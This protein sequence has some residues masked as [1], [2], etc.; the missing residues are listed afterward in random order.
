LAPIAGIEPASSPVNGRPRAPCSPDGN[1]F[2]VENPGVEPGTPILQGSTAARCLPR[3]WSW[4]RATLSASSARRFHQISLP[5]ALARMPVI[6]TGPDEWR[7]TAR[8]S[9]YTRESI[10]RKSGRRFSAENARIKN[11]ICKNLIW[12]E[13]DGIEPLARRDRVYSAA[14]APACPYLHFPI[15]SFGCRDRSR[16]DLEQLM[17][18][19]GSRTSL[20]NNAKVF[21]AIGSSGAAAVCEF[22]LLRPN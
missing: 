14:T 4:F 9:S 17:R 22:P 3:A 5:G 10:F 12:W 1:K 16:T 20:Q 19:P 21:I 11:L 13:A 7:S 2:L 6:E 15:V 18:L 8:P